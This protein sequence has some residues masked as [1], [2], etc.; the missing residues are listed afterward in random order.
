MKNLLLVAFLTFLVSC[1]NETT[2]EEKVTQEDNIVVQFLKE[3]NSLKD[4]ESKTPVAD[5]QKEVE[6]VAQ[7]AISFNK[8]NI[9]TVLEEASNYKS[10]IIIVEDHTILKIKDLT[11]CK[12]S[13]SWGTCM[14]MGE[15]LIKKGAFVN[16]EDYINNIIGLP[17]NQKRIIYFFNL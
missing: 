16:K 13:G 8:D 10:W 4:F 14:P 3:I 5:F 11:N 2:Q 9:K 6:L 1:G 7:K 17:D 15:G 12:P